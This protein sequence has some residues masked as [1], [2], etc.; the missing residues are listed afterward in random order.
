MPCQKIGGVIVCYNRAY[1]Y[2]SIYFEYNEY[3]GVS[4]L[5]KDGS[6]STRLGKKFLKLFD[7]WWK[8]PK[9][10]QKKYEVTE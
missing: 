3:T 8:L 10:Q 2:K 5:N 9:K 7:E 4:R 1:K 6:I